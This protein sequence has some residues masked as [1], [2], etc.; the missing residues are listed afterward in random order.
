[1]AQP[2]F[3]L[4]Q[5]QL[6]QKDKETAAVPAKGPATAGQGVAS[7]NK[8]KLESHP[9]RGTSTERVLDQRRAPQAP[10]PC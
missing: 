5:F 8:A 7:Q 9:M 4:G 3:A 6:N 10:N 1:M 2:I